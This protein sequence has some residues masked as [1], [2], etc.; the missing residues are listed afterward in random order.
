[1][2]FQSLTVKNFRC[3]YKE[4]TL[5]FAANSERNVTVV[6]AENGTGKTTLLNAFIWCLYGEFTDDVEQP[7][8]VINSRHMVDAGQFAECSV[9]LRFSHDSLHYSL[10]RKHKIA[11]KPVANLQCIGNGQA[12]K[13]PFE[14]V[15]AM[16]PK[17]MYPYFFF[18]GERIA[19]MLQ[20][21]GSEGLKK[22]IKT[23][24]GL[25]LLDAAKAQLEDVSKHFRSRMKNF[26]QDQDFLRKQGQLDSVEENLEAA[27]LTKG[28]AEKEL[29]AAQDCLKVLNST[30]ADNQ[31]VRDLQLTRDRLGNDAE[32]I[33]SNISRVTNDL[34]KY[35]SRDAFV[36][37]LD[38]AA[39]AAHRVLKSCGEDH[40]LPPMYVDSFIDQ[41][42]EKGTCICGRPIDPN[43]REF[44]A[45]S[46]R[47]NL[48]STESV[49]IR[50]INAAKYVENLPKE[51]ELKQENYRSLM[52]ERADWDEKL[53]AVNTDLAIVKKEIESKGELRPDVM[54]AE[55]KRD[56]VVA[57]IGA[58]GQKIRDLKLEIEDNRAQKVSLENDIN[59]LAVKN[60]KAR[61]FS[62]YTQKI[63]EATEFVG[64]I[65]EYRIAKI[66]QELEQKVNQQLQAIFTKDVRARL[67]EQ[68]GYHIEGRDT[69]TA[70]YKTAIKSTGENQISYLAFIGGLVHL[71]RQSTANSQNPYFVG[72]GDYP[73]V[74]DS[75]FGQLD[76][77][78]REGISK[79]IPTVSAQV[80]VF[81]SS[82]QY[83]DVVANSLM[84]YID[85]HYV[86]QVHS[87]KEKALSF[88]P[89][90]N[91][92]GKIVRQWLSSPDHTYSEIVD[93]KGLYK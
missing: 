2:I 23:V 32:N 58:L 46:A 8:S 20:E 71:A 59:R 24:M 57:D 90:I 60:D 7:E 65:L 52:R 64:F 67:T 53:K 80:I 84:P 37:F 31:A 83:N 38:S 22:A 81:L 10:Q 47:K 55:S 88:P 35:L 51:M 93:V 17:G 15:Y 33:K 27:E 11:S 76:N 6:H 26:E 16:L 89:S 4:F 77:Q 85:N 69:P 21:G 30:L 45:V 74:M 56:H 13:V 3:F 61:I 43:S 75:P 18:N 48:N 87:N 49:V 68:F 86:I 29:S 92:D 39:K 9:E 14:R 5:R 50:A 72:G 40:M 91:I 34:F 62:I 25:E 63:K 70:A 41:L 28:E 1:V 42:L 82:S 12:E 73:I 66:R 36:G 19:K 44:E 79:W 54:Q 78:Y